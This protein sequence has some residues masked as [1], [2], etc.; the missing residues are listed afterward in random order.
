VVVVDSDASD[1][2]PWVTSHGT[3]THEYR[4]SF[5]RVWVR[6]DPKLPMGYP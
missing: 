4:Y 3:H 6:V 5:K 2:N 1:G